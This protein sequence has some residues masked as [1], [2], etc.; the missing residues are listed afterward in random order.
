MNPSF[1]LRRVKPTGDYAVDGLFAGFWAGAAMAIFLALV[2]LVDGRPPLETIAYF[3]PTAAGSW[4]TGAFSHLAVSAIYGLVFGLLLDSH[5]ETQR[6]IGFPGSV[7]GGIVAFDEFTRLNGVDH[8]RVGQDAP[9]EGPSAEYGR[10]LT[11]VAACAECHAP[12]LAG[13]SGE[14]GPPPGPNLTPGEDLARWSEGDFINTLRTG[15]T[16]DGR[17]LDGEDMPW[18]T[19]GQMSD[20]ELKAIWAYLHSLEPLP[21]NP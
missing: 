9:A 4:L 12:N 17:Q 10:Y 5:F 20:T 6:Q 1:R 11:T 14:D 21:D 18:P 8:E 7:L 16:P 2:G 13:Y 3:D 15:Q 19:L